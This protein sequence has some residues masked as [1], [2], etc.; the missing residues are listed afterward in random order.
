[1]LTKFCASTARSKKS[2]AHDLAA[3]VYVNIEDKDPC[4][5]EDYLDRCVWGLPIGH[6]GIVAIKDHLRPDVWWLDIW[7]PDFRFNTSTMKAA[8]LICYALGCKFLA[9]DNSHEP[10]FNY[11]CKK[12]GFQELEPNLWSLKLSLAD[13]SPC[14]KYSL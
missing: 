2:L 6:G 5:L 9:S 10:R 13:R 7:A 1:M 8:I 11:I 14:L 12:I 3:R 4:P